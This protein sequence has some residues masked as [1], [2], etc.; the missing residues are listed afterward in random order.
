VE[1]SAELAQFFLYTLTAERFIYFYI[2]LV[3]TGRKAVGL[4]ESAKAHTVGKSMT[5]ASD[6]FGGSVARECFS[7]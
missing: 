6:V 1:L 5:I 4:I 3:N 7:C 2:S